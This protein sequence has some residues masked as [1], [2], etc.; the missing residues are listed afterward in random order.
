MP[1]PGEV[2]GSSVPLFLPKETSARGSTCGSSSCQSAPQRW[3]GRRCLRPF[4]ATHPIG[5]GWPVSSVPPV[6]P[7]C[8]FLGLTDSGLCSKVALPGEEQTWTPIKSLKDI[9]RLMNSPPSSLNGKHPTYPNTHTHTHTYTLIHT[10]TVLRAQPEG[11]AKHA[12]VCTWE[13][14][15]NPTP[16]CSRQS[17]TLVCPW[18]FAQ[19][20]HLPHSWY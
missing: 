20:S 10:Y 15:E 19:F 8:P 7:T 3:W 11:I 14:K 12:L 2:K 17:E 18:A 16:F 13:N 4:Q 9:V 5:S 1:S 6:S